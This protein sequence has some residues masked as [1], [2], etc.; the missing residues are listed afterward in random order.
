MC[1]KDI[2][3]SMSI[4]KRKI[5]LQLKLNFFLSANI[6]LKLG[7]KNL[8]KKQYF[9]LDYLSDVEIKCILERKEC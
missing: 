9:H 5:Y 6:R 4:C 2:S 7:Y 1:V 8:Y 3:V